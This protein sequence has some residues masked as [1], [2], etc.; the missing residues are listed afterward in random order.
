MRILEVY[1][2]RTIQ[3]SCWEY[4][5]KAYK[6]HKD[7]P[8]DFTFQSNQLGLLAL[9]EISEHTIDMIRI[10]ESDNVFTFIHNGKRF[11]VTNKDGK[12]AT[13]R[14][15]RVGHSLRKL[16]IAGEFNE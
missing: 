7:V 10:I 15:I 12:E 11:I 8:G 9:Y 2:N 5:K 13:E 1:T 3:D 14:E 16:Y 4:D 6:L